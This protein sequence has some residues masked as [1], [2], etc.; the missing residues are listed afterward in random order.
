MWTM[1]AFAIT[2]GAGLAWYSMGEISPSFIRA[3]AL[4]GLIGVGIGVLSQTAPPGEDLNPIATPVETAQAGGAKIRKRLF[5]FA[6]PV[7]KPSD[8]DKP[9]RL[10]YWQWAA[11]A[12]LALDLLAA[13]WGLN[14]GG[15]LKLFTRLTDGC[16]DSIAGPGWEAISAPKTGILAQI[17]AFPALRVIR[18][19]RG[20][21][22]H[23][24]SAFAEH[25]HV[26][27]HPFDQQLRPIAA[28]ALRGL[29]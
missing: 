17:R 12:F 20:L 29:E 8:P 19:R 11:G 7:S 4:M 3:S 25:G 6:P 18:E 15:T 22:E 9:Y 5:Q 27:R 24:G 16:R 1:G 2:V 26:G 10:E 14:P 28:R 13:G 23:T 21:A